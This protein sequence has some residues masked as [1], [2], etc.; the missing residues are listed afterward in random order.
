MHDLG[1]ARRR[2]IKP[3]YDHCPHPLE[4][5]CSGIEDVKLEVGE[6]GKTRRSEG[7]GVDSA[8]RGAII[9]G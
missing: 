8:G 1:D 6:M 4:S 7:S 2:R 3:P 9:V 5:G